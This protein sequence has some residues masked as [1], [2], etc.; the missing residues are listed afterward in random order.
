MVLRPFPSPSEV[1]VAG[2]LTLADGRGQ[3]DACARLWQGGGGP[4]KCSLAASAP[5]E[6]GRSPPSPYALHPRCSHPGGHQSVSPVRTAGL[7]GQPQPL[8]SVLPVAQATCD[9]QPSAPAWKA[10][11]SR[12]PREGRS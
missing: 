3:S 8:A 2:N 10:T 7:R 5:Y 6:D 4:K 1:G 9:L 11:A 12:E